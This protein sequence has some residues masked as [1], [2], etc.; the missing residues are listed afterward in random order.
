MKAMVCAA[1]LVGLVAGCSDS[2]KES[3]KPV[4]SAPQTP[5]PIIATP[6]ART[7][8]YALRDGYEY[9]YERPPS[10]E[11]INK[12]QA[13]TA[14]SMV[15]YAG[16]SNGN[17]QAYMHD[18]ASNAVVVV[19]CAKPCEFMKVMIFARPNGPAIS[20]DR[21]RASPGVLGA[22]IIE[23]AINGE[24]EQF[25]GERDGRKYTVQF[26]EKSGLKL[27]WLGKQG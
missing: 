3:A 20:T 21:M 2:P 26:N 25:I 8:N 18:K 23:D 16:V 27:N 19:E 9:G 10:Q 12:G 13:T 17:H 15:K 24:L 11:E 1:V 22:M 4:A 7:H 5:E 6:P 14:L